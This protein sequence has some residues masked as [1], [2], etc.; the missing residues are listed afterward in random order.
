MLEDLSPATRREH[1]LFFHL[2]NVQSA[3]G[4]AQLFVSFEHHLGVLEVGRCFH[5]GLRPHLGI[6]GLKDARSDEYRFRPHSPPQPSPSPT[7]NPPPAKIRHTPL[8]AF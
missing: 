5:Y 3:H 4:F 2:T 1:V 6:A 7:A 8:P